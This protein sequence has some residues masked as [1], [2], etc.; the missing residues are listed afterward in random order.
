MLLLFIGE[1]DLLV[2]EGSNIKVGGAPGAFEKE[3]KEMEDKLDEVKRIL[4][5]ANFTSADLDQLREKLNTIR[6]ADVYVIY[7]FFEFL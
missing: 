7:L 5:G 3:F 6:S 2:E 4:S 1:T